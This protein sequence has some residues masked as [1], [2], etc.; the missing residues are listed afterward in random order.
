LVQETVLVRVIS[1]ATHEAPTAPATPGKTS[2]LS[3]DMCVGG[4]VIIVTA[5]RAGNVYCFEKG[6]QAASNYFDFNLEVSKVADLL[7]L[8]LLAPAYFYIVG[9]GLH[10]QSITLTASLEN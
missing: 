10:F 4:L 2:A 8:H 5:I 6:C 7:G 9:K 1:Y 3:N